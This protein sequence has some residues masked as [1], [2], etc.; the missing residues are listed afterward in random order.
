LL[1]EEKLGRGEQR[2]NLEN[3]D[4]IRRKERGSNYS[5]SKI[6]S[7]SKAH[8]LSN[9]EEIKKKQKTEQRA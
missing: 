4:I 3:K 6:L 7:L 5:L 2:V 1:F 8:I 9:R